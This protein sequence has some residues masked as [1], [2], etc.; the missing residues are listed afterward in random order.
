VIDPPLARASVADAR[1]ASSP[2]D[3]VFDRH[4]GWFYIDLPE[5]Q[6]NIADNPDRLDRFAIQLVNTTA[7]PMDFR[8]LFAFDTPLS[9]ASLVCVLSSVTP[10]MPTEYRPD[11]QKL[12]PPA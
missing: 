11:L 7:A 2:Y 4:R 12:A 3:I 5:Q 6:W 10:W 1:N 9:P 8:L